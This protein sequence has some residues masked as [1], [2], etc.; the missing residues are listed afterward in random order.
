MILL[1]P[2]CALP[3]VDS[4]YLFCIILFCVHSIS[5][6]PAAP[7]IPISPIARSRTSGRPLLPIQ[8]LTRRL[9]VNQ[10][11]ARSYLQVNGSPQSGRQSSIWKVD[12]VP[13]ITHVI[14]G[15]LCSYLL[16]MATFTACSGAQSAFRFKW[17]R[18]KK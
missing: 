16:C 12:F 11:T 6:I 18:C 5:L 1:R 9:R 2:K 4:C 17:I 14:S 7:P 10:P 13:G 15:R 3:S 8:R